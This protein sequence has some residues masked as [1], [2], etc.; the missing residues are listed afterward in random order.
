VFV[1]LNIVVLTCYFAGS[2]LIVG[3]KLLNIVVLGGYF[4]G[5]VLVA[6][7][8]LARDGLAKGD[9]LGSY[10]LGPFTVLRKL[11]VVVVPNGHPLVPNE[12]PV[13]NTLVFCGF[14]VVAGGGVVKF[15]DVGG[16]LVSGV[17]FVV[18]VLLVVFVFVLAEK[19]PLPVL[20]RLPVVGLLFPEKMLVL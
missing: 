17:G 20:N 13:P 3:G 16:G 7:G 4:G 8:G 14:V 12:P 19:I 1:L 2:L 15:V 9:D 18:L 10:F 5:S 6:T 11:V